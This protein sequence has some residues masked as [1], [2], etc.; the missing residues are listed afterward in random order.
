MKVVIFETEP[1]E[2]A[3]FG[4]LRD[5]HE[6]L[7]VEEPLRAEN[8]S[9]FRDAEI[10]SP[11]I[12]SELGRSV[13]KRLPSLA[14]I[15]TRSTGFEHIDTAYCADH[16]IT[17]SNVPSYGENTVA[18]HVFALLLTISHRILE[19]VDRARSGPF[20]PQG[21]QGFDLEGKTLGVVGAGGIGRCV[22]RIARGFGMRVIAS[23][24]K[25]DEALARQLDFRYAPFDQV[26]STADIVTL[27]VPAT[28]DTHN[29][30]SEREF[31]LMKDGAIVINTARGSL[32]DVRALIR[33]LRNGK[34]A[35]AGLDVL[36]GEP[37]IRE[38][39][40]LISSTFCDRS[41]L[42]DLLADHVLLRMPNVVITPHSAFN[43]HE[44]LGRI[45]DTTVENI[46]A[47]ANARPK[48]VVAGASSQ[49]LPS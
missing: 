35:A 19:A 1:H 10:V 15:A 31:A 17:V 49:G 23:D 36:P 43:T 14:F 47:F 40:E 20:S 46:T 28:P 32:V 11:F 21:L 9:T 16:N 34:V 37:A 12:Y 33:A 29:L 4:E 48:N 3:A 5:Q 38:E 22:I 8:A 26:L 41:D 44:A 39:T 30:L 42:R 18:E 27:H 13:L 2:A 7:I 25:P 24:I 6:I 45:I